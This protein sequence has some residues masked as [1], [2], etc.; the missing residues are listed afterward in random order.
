MKT[1]REFIV[2]AEKA[3]IPMTKEQIAASRSRRAAAAQTLAQNASTPGEGASAA[4][5]T[6]RLR[7]ASGETIIGNNPSS[8][9]QPGSTVNSSSTAQPQ[10]SAR[11]A[12][13]YSNQ[14]VGRQD[15]IRSTQTP[16][17]Q[18]PN[19]SWKSRVPQPLRNV[20]RGGI[21]A[22]GVLGAV[23]A[24]NAARQGD[25]FDVQV[26]NPQTLFKVFGNL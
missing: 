5:A 6:E 26:A 8:Q 18:T 19:A 1:F 9:S 10:S 7:T 21:R 23:D 14:G 22:F 16:N 17:A 15:N 3:A 13:T 4:S 11:T 2:I 25:V 24:V 12:Q 20:G